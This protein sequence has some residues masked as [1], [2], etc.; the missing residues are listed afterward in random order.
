MKLLNKPDIFSTGDFTLQK[1]ME[2]EILSPES[3]NPNAKLGR[4]WNHVSIGV[5][6]FMIIEVHLSATADVFDGPSKI[7]A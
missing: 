7:K 6:I 4:Q 5:S 2:K 1:K 3:R